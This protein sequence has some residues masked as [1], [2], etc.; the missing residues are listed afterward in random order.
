MTGVPGG[1]IP[2]SSEISTM[3]NL[4][5]SPRREAGGTLAAWLTLLLA[6]GLYAAWWPLF[7]ALVPDAIDPL[8]ERLALLGM[9]L[10]FLATAAVPRYRHRVVALSHIA[11]YVTTVH[12]FTLLWRNSLA[13]PYVA[14]VF[15]LLAAVTLSFVTLRALLAYS[16]SVVV[17]A[18][19]VAALAPAPSDQ[20]WFLV[21]GVI[22][23]QAM[24][25]ALSWR[26]LVLQSRARRSVA[27]TR[28]F[29]RAV[30]DAI[31]DPVFVLDDKLR[32]LLVNEAMGGVR[33]APATDTGGGA[34]RTGLLSELARDLPVALGSS[35][36]VEKEIPLSRVDQPPG[37][38]LV[39]LRGSRLAAGTNCL[40][41]V[42]RDIS[43][44]KS[45]EESLQAKIR[46]LE[47]AR[48]KVS[49]LQGLLP[50]CMHC[51]RIRSD[52]EWQALESYIES[53]STAI[54]S[55]GLCHTCLAEH[56]P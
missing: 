3:M 37:T 4:P 42:V 30:L 38:A 6:A 11:L 24:L 40:V 44:R 54:F 5:P 31:P 26:N 28:D 17:L 56:Y 18:I 2:P 23:A 33:G 55:H 20:A 46:E 1:E 32:C 9:C 45:L 53:H 8:S 51:G 41:G 27:R 7:L 39:K 10:V 29:L 12:F 15:V 52:G 19:V 49:Q 13:E 47:Q 34:P 36:P 14:A 50:I 22:S 16:V 35:A 25:A 21:V 43:E 48:A